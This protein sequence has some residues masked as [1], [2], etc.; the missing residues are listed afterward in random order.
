[1]SQPVNQPAPP[2]SAPDANEKAVVVYGHAGCPMV[3]P[4]IGVL[5]ASG[6]PYRYADIHRDEVARERVRSINQGNESVPTLVFAD[7]STLTEPSTGALRRALE[8]R[9]YHVPLMARLAG[10]AWL[11]LIGLGVLWALLSALGVL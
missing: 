8:A 11:L 10:N 6:V 9:G 4:V 7:G 3:G 2:S 5:K 1:M